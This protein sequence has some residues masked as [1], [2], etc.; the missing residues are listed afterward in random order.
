MSAVTNPADDANEEEIVRVHVWD[1]LVRTTH[2]VIAISIFVLSVTG[3]EI[4]HPVIEVP[5]RAGQHFVMGTVRVVHFY[6][7]IAFT[8]AVLS[9]I[10]WMFFGKRHARWKEFIPVEPERRAGFLPMLAFYLFARKKPL[11]TVG[12]NPLAAAA[13]VIVF[14]LYLVMI[15]TGLAM[16][17][18]DAPG[19]PIAF[20]RVFL[21]VF[22]GIT[23]ARWLHHVTMWLLLGFFIHHLYSAILTAVVERNG[24]LDSIFTGDKWVSRE[25]AARDARNS[26]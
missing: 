13:Y 10:A 9:R 12:H 18:V 22:R 8:L 14:G 20:M 16:Y 15:V 4:G 24:T 1:G 2:W 21:P 25:L 23:G 3:I 26:S 6:T 11:P 7:A 19:A 5:G 17:S